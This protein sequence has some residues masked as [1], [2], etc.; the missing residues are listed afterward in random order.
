MK[1]KIYILAG[2]SRQALMYLQSRQL[3]KTDFT[4]LHSPEQLFGTDKPTVILTG[5]YWELKDFYKWEIL[6]E[7]R[8][9]EIKKEPTLLE[10]EIKG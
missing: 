10:D 5:T 9:A 2:N 4:I 1:K 3:P 8:Q 6:L 7:N